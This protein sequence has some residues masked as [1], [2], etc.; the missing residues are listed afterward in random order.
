[1][2]CFCCA[3]PLRGC[4]NSAVFRPSNGIWYSQRSQTGFTFSQFGQNG[5]VPVPGDHD[6]DGKND[7]AI[8][9]SGNWYVLRS[10]NNSFAGIAFG[11]ATDVPVPAAYLP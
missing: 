1:M 7:L 10:G 9:R 8:F 11:S 5:D 6:N 4:F 2:E 3:S